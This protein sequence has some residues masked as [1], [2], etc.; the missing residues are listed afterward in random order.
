MRKSELILPT[1]RM[2]KMRRNIESSLCSLRKRKNFPS[3]N[4]C[5]RKVKSVWSLV[6]EYLAEPF[7]E[8]SLIKK[9]YRPSKNVFEIACKV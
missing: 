5:L 2:E 9:K 1:L 6:L 4:C 8:I 3:H 7:V